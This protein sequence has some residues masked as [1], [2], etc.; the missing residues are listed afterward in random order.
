MKNFT[1]IFGIIALVAVVGFSMT[2]CPPEPPPGDTVV[3]IAAIQGVTAPATGATPV[4]TITETAQ[5]TGTVSW[6]GNP[7]TFAASTAYTATI[8]LTAKTGFTFDGVAANFFTVAGA[9]AAN[10]VNSGTITAVFPATGGGSGTT[11]P[12]GGGTF[13]VTGIPS[14]YNGKY[15][16]FMGNDDPP[17]MFFIGCQ[18]Y[19]YELNV[20]TAVQIVDGSVNLP[21]WKIEGDVYEVTSIVS[22]SGNDTFLGWL[23]ICELETV[24]HSAI[25]EPII[26]AV[27]DSIAFLNGNAERTWDSADGYVP[28]GGDGTFTV[29]GIPSVYNGKYAALQGVGINRKA[30]FYGC[31]SINELAEEL[32]PVQIVNGSVSLPMWALEL[33][34]DDNITSVESYSGNDIVDI[35]LYLFNSATFESVINGLAFWESVT[36]TNGGAER[37]WE[38]ADNY[39]LNV[40]STDGRLT[41]TNLSTYEG[42][43]ILA[44]VG[45]A[46]SPSYFAT[47]LLVNVPQQIVIIM[48]QISDGSV[49]L[50]VWKEEGGEYISYTG[51]DNLTFY[52]AVYDSIFID[53]DSE[54]IATGE[55]T[56]TFTN[57]IANVS[58]GTLTPVP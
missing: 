3:N 54:P 18:D 5:Y 7:S 4:T 31:Q 35:R 16:M 13:T 47:F 56:V 48:G 8:T 39:Y 57:G 42:K 24:D 46:E 30:Y 10:A 33:D 29:T 37:T 43:Y 9:S 20:T 26:S 11:P 21:M 55:V 36:F 44:A 38:S 12:G 2:A 32:I 50:N 41:I 53:S 58:A 51:N 25:M 6:N 28:S 49:T 23:H 52:V 22:Y 17:T 14:V 1:K 15:A 27:W 34:D 40:P 19:D 45:S